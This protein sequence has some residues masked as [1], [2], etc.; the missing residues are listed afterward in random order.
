M[1]RPILIAATLSAALAAGLVTA[2]NAIADAAP[3][4]AREELAALATPAAVRAGGHEA[5]RALRLAR[6]M[7]ADPSLAVIVNLRA[8]ER[9][10][11]SD[12][13][14]AELP[15]FYRSQL[16]RTD[17]ALVRNF[18]NYRLARMEMREQ[19]AKGALETLMRNLDENL[20]RAGSRPPA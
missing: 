8:I 6:A 19:D 18:I 3:F 13:R 4:A 7:R 15:S 10:Y 9:V 2:G 20:A 11:R 12:G 17:D 16:G 5:R 1:Y 14:A